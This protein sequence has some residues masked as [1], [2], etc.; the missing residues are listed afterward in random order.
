MKINYLLIVFLSFFQSCESLAI[1][2]HLVGNYY[3]IA[4]DDQHQLGLGYHTPEDEDTY[5]E[6]VPATVFAVGF[7]ENY[8]ILKQHPYIFAK[9]PNTSITNY[10]ILR[11][12]KL[13]NFKTQKGLYGPLTY[14]Q[15][16]LKRQELGIP[17]SLNFSKVY[18]DLE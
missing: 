17:D 16:N 8:F 6:I 11:N 2:E 1:K 10:Y 13:F 4:S 5:G 3:L 9:P 15:Y 18:K 7:N 12:Q 14:D